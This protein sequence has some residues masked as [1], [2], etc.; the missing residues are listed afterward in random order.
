MPKLAIL[1]T[2]PIQYF[3]PLYR[4][5]AQE[6]GIDLTVYFCS[7]QGAEEY[8]DSGFGE[9]FKWDVPLLEGYKYRFL[10]NL[11]TR[12]SVGGFWSL[13]NLD[14]VRELRANNYD[15]L[16][17]N[18][19][20]CATYLIG[21]LAARWLNI[22]VLMR[23]ET[24]L[25][26]QRSKLKLA[27]RKLLMRLLYNRLCDVCLPIGTRNREFYLAHG[28]DSGKMFTVPYAVDNGYF[29]RAANQFTH[30]DETK[31]DL[32]LPLNMPLVLSV[33][34][35]LPGKKLMDLLVAFRRIR[36][37]GTEAALL[38]VGSGEEEVN[39]KDY[40]RDH[41]LPDVHFFGFR[42]QSELPKFYSIADLFVFPSASE[43]W[44]LILNEVMCA[45]VPV[46][47][48]SNIGAVPDLVH[49]G[50]NGFAFESGNI[51][52]LVG[53]IQRLLESAE[54][55]A[56]MGERSRSIISH[57]DHERCVQGIKD[58]LEYVARPQVWSAESEAA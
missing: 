46:I 34:K 5:L 2:H 54:L 27:A 51:D 29:A 26:L 7:H 24:H 9:R 31:T 1:N 30:R 53:C 45:G 32:G 28:V 4:R 47:A 43:T 13:I 39:L 22:P 12:D 37:G 56:R 36:A 14:I 3:A 50:E 55:R 57:W 33:S 20:N 49:Q 8:F 16:W 48:S 38:F 18:G 58:A 40:V 15:A 41:Q 23:C 35:M 10:K 11:R 19:H 25:L 21:I 42:N 44:G 6:P 52:E 17:V